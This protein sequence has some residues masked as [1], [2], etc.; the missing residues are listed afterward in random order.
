M[1]LNQWSCGRV[2]QLSLLVKGMTLHL[3]LLYIHYGSQAWLIIVLDFVPPSFAHHE[4][5]SSVL[6]GENESK[7]F[8]VGGEARCGDD[9]SPSILLFHFVS[10]AVKISQILEHIL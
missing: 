6:E 9:P 2:W 5:T 1:L 3:S 8:L 7:T 4:T 10:G